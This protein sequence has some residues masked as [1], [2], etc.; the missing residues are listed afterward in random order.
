MNFN[1]NIPIY[2][3]I[4]DECKRRMITGVYA[5]GSKVPPVRELA[6]EFGVN[7]NTVQRAMSDLEREGLFI[8]ERTSGRFICKDTELIHALKK[9]V[10]NDRILSFL[11]E[12]KQYGCEEEEIIQMIRER[13]DNGKAD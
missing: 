7:P 4:M 11:N 2:I 9:S 3:Q 13:Y 8:S 6:V 5:P 12:M 1:D 10:V